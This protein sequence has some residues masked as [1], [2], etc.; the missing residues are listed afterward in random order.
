MVKYYCFLLK[1]PMNGNY[2]RY[3]FNLRTKKHYKL[4]NIYCLFL[5]SSN[6]ILWFAS[7]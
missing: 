4:S 3:S 7:L 1:L 5:S 2:F 6:F